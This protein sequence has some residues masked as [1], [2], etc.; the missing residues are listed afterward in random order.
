MLADEFRKAKPEP[1]PTTTVQQLVDKYL[2]DKQDEICVEAWRGYRKFLLPF[3]AIF[4][5]RPAE[6]LTGDEAEDFAKNQKWEGRNWSSTYR[7]GFLGTLV[8]AFRWAVKKKLVVSSPVEG[9]KKP[10]KA[11]RGT[12]AVIT[13]DEHKKLL[14]VADD[15]FR[16]LLVVLWHT[17]ARPGE[18]TALTAEQVKGCADGVIPL[19]NH[20]TTHKGKSRFL[21]LTGEALQVAKKRTEQVGT[22][23]LWTGQNGQLTPKAISSKMERLVKKAGIRRGVIAYGYRHTFATTALTK[24]VPD[25]TVA[26]LLGHADTSMLHKHYSH[27]T[28][29][30]QTLKAA[31][32][33]VRAESNG[34]T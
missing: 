12:K 4:G 13:E 6:S 26:A 10:P 20:K 34:G 11:S 22:G 19:D 1:T 9:L 3:A 32:S 29:Q 17:G 31:M 16:D 18:I 24:G 14:G 25:A 23:L 33:R 27:L 5:N 28:A 2:K 7:A 8:S 30:T 15:D 21:I